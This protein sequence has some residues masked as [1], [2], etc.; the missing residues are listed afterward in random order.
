MNETVVIN[1]GATFYRVVTLYSDAAKTTPLSLT[2][3]TPRSSLMNARTG[4]KVAAFACAIIDETA[5]TIAWTM[6][7]LTTKTIP[8]NIQ[9][10]AD[11]DLDDVDGITTDRAATYGVYLQAGQAPA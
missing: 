8:A 1:Q 5:G 2:G 3:K 7:R 9:Y 10:F 4:G 11:I 6:P